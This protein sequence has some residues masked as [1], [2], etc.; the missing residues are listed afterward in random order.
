[1]KKSLI[2]LWLLTSVS[3]L[4]ISG[5]V[6]HQTPVK[7]PAEIRMWWGDKESINSF[8]ESPNAKAKKWLL[9]AIGE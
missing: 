8:L 7:E 1:M 4:S 6:T 5:C 9:E 3:L 2:V